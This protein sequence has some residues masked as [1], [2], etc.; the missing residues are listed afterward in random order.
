[1]KI[2]QLILSLQ[3]LMVDHGDTDVV[4]RVAPNVFEEI[5]Y[6]GSYLGENTNKEA[7][8][9]YLVIPTGDQ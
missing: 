4:V 9:H 1:M 2:S 8:F 7:E 3:E 6:A 5:I